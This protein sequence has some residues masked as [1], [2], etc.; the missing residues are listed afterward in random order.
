MKTPYLFTKT[1]GTNSRIAVIIA[2]T[3]LLLSLFYNPYLYNLKGDV[4]FYLSFLILSASG[5]ILFLFLTVWRRT[6]GKL[7]ATDLCLILF[8]VICVFSSVIQGKYHLENESL[9]TLL[10]LYLVY[11]MVRSGGLLFL[12]ALGDLLS[13]AFVL[14]CCL[15]V[16][17]LFH[18]GVD[19]LLIA[20]KGS[21]DNSS[22]LANFLVFTSPLVLYRMNAF[23]NKAIW[24]YTV[25][26]Y[27][28]IALTMILI[29]QARTAFLTLL[30]LLLILWKR[31]GKK[32]LIT[33]ISNK[34]L[35]LAMLLLFI[36]SM[37]IKRGSATGRLLIWQVS[38][39][40]LGDKPLTGSGYASFPR[41]YPI[42][43]AGYFGSGKG[44]AEFRKVAGNVGIAFNEYLNIYLETGIFGLLAFSGILI[45][46]LR[47]KISAENSHR[48]FYIKLSLAALLLLSL[49]SY[50]MQNTTTLLLVFLEVGFLCNMTEG[51]S[52]IRVSK[53]VRNVTCLMA[54]GF[55]LAAVLYFTQRSLD[56]HRW[57]R[58]RG[59]VVEGDTDG[60]REYNEIYRGLCHN[61]AFTYD[62]GEMLYHVGL[63]SDCSKVLEHAALNTVETDNLNLLGLSYQSLKQYKA[64]EN[65]FRINSNMVPG[66]FYPKYL[67]VKLYLETKDTVRAMALADTIVNMPVKVHSDQVFI[68]KN[69]MTKLVSSGAGNRKQ[70]H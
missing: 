51:A 16:Y 22:Q 62:Y 14:E 65:C 56:V 54:A 9:L 61:V 11:W 37:A 5:F 25:T 4:G 68:I 32:N 20:C 57:K 40:H 8:L 29:T 53:F 30:V 52:L 23:R 36:G 44:T 26:I 12:E 21:F 7:L 39:R 35:A 3:S 15:F 34:W 69:E 50:P 64:S 66:A 60:I 38:A 42:W 27:L 59:T 28:S 67:L 41:V 43:Q 2:A 10:Q 6:A 13:I 24:P 46:I 48:G 47:Q 31:S 55:C 58:V 17:Q 49:F 70:Q 18:P 19:P 1:P 45:I 33:R 63:F